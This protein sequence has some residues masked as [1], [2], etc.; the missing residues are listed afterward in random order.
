MIHYSLD[1]VSEIFNSTGRI[2]ADLTWDIDGDLEYDLSSDDPDMRKAAK[3]H[4]KSGLTLAYAKENLNY[5]K[6]EYNSGR[7][8][9][10][11]GPL[12]YDLDFNAD[13]VVFSFSRENDSDPDFQTTLFA[14]KNG[15]FNLNDNGAE[16][17]IQGL[18][19]F[20]IANIRFE[21]NNG[22]K[23]HSRDWRLIESVRQL[24]TFYEDLKNR[25]PV[26]PEPNSL[27]MSVCGSVIYVAQ[28]SDA[29]DEMTGR[30][31]SGVESKLGSGDDLTFDAT[32]L[33]TDVDDVSFLP[34]HPDSIFSLK[35]EVMKNLPLMTTPLFAYGSSTF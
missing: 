30:I 32:G 15:G 6:N 14:F 26:F 34:M 33:V 27:Y 10:K 11:T 20:Q 17:Y 5:I 9:E 22:T 35:S 16:I 24:S 31:V 2:A 13:R 3:K 12:S 19:Y 18:S 21:A 28:R 25:A 29:S 7:A 1:Y 8:S 4:Q 23:H